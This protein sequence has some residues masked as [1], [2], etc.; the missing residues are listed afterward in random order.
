MKPNWLSLQN[1][2]PS[3][4]RRNRWLAY[5]VA[6]AAPTGIML[7]MWASENHTFMTPLYP[8]FTLAIMS[9]A[10][11]GGLYPGLLSYGLSVFYTDFLILQPHYSLS[12]ADPKE[13][14]RFAAFAVV[15]IAVCALVANLRKLHEQY[16]REAELIK[17]SFD[18]IIVWRLH[19]VIES[20]NLGAE[21]LYGYSESEASGRVTHDLLKS[22]HPKPWPQIEPEFRVNRRWEGEIHHRTK[23]GREV[24]VWARKRLVRGDD[25][26]ERVLEVNRDLTER[27]QT[28]QALIRAEKLSAAGRLAATLAHEVNNPLEAAISAIY[29]AS[30]DPPKSAEMLAV[31]DQ[32][33]RR[34]AHMVHQT[35]HQ[36]LGF[37]RENPI[38]AQVSLPAVIDDVLKLYDAKLQQRGISVL[39]RYK[40]GTCKER[41]DGCF[42]INGSELRQI[43]SNLL[44]NG[45]DALRD[46]GTLHIR[47]SRINGHG[48][49]ISLTIADNGC[50]IRTE[51]LK[52]IFEPFFTTKQAVGTGL[53]LWVT[54]ELVRKHNGTIKVRSRKDKGTVFRI[55]FPA[56]APA[57]EGKLESI[58][59]SNNKSVVGY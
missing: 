54:Q 36:T 20:W 37:Y 56:T 30:T 51:N 59:S 55:T 15:G 45:I 41:A 49:R 34:V 57:A 3:T 29:L 44:A 16:R 39:R 13:R 33:L 32:E 24:V 2:V 48:P 47:V 53:G 31:A 58:R 5:S 11:L 43:V 22:I 18:A 23:D 46:H 25:G 28:E 10:L 6:F 42:L 12:I 14:L 7:V 17:V 4:S 38:P 26:I 19:G 8:F 1:V 52:R 50:G 21:Q 9:S 40:R 35:L 27:K